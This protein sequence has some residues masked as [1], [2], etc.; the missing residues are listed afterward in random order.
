[1][2]KVTHL[3]ISRI[4]VYLDCFFLHDPHPQPLVEGDTFLWA[5]AAPV[6]LLTTCLVLLHVAIVEPPIH[7]YSVKV[8][9]ISCLFMSPLCQHNIWYRTC[10][11]D[12]RLKANGFRSEGVYA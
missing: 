1:M 2:Y 9:T 3:I 8:L 4:Y 10:A 12:N 6:F 11:I 5:S 7:L